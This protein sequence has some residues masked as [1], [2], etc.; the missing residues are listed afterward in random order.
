MT[1]AKKII[2]NSLEEFNDSL[3]D[4]FVRKGINDT[5]H[6]SDSLRAIQESEK[7][8][9]SVGSDYIEVL[10]KGRGPGTGIPVDNLRQWI[11][12]KLGITEDK[13]I[14]RVNYFVQKKAVEK[15]SDIFLN[16][17][18]GLEID[19]KIPDFTKDLTKKLQIH[20]VADV[21]K[22]LNFF[23]SQRI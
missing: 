16:P 7:V 5:R 13:D 18:K 9:Q 21:K 10:D 19:E 3:R 11:I 1:T 23:S 12:S 22:Q 8:F 17:S 15:G 2:L 4:E 20:A 14:A 6:A